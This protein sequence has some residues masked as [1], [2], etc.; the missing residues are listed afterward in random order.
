MGHAFSR[1]ERA[2]ELGERIAFGYDGID[3]PV[4]MSARGD[5]AYGISVNV[6]MPRYDE[7]EGDTDVE[8]DADGD[9]DGDTDT[10]VDAESAA[11]AGAPARRRGQL[12]QRFALPDP[13]AYMK[14]RFNQLTLYVDADGRMELYNEGTPAVDVKN[15]RQGQNGHR[16]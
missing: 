1:G 12:M 7:A 3:P 8:A 5:D 4:P 16:A 6:T 11:C 13:G 14:M 10:D 2:L 9:T 15:G